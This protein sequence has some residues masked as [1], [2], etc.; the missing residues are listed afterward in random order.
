MQVATGGWKGQ[1]QRCWQCYIF[2]KCF[3][4]SK[5]LH[6]ATSYKLAHASNIRGS[7]SNVFIDVEDEI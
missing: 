7:N 3:F 4:K 2:W 1:L 5:C 6:L